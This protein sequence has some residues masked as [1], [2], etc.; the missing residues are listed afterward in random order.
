[1]KKQ[2]A[3]M[4]P[5]RFVVEDAME[6]VG[7]L[8]AADHVVKQELKKLS[9]WWWWWTAQGDDIKEALENAPPGDLNIVGA[10]FAYELFLA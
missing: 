1:M 7:A 2:I 8:T 10:C 6:E 3:V 9:R 5:D 4:N